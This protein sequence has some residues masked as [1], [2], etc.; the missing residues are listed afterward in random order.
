MGR[1]LEEVRAG[2]GMMRES[3]AEGRK[4]GEADE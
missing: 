2:R 4:G 1:I 3:G